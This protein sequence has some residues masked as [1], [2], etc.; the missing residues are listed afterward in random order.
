MQKLVQL[1]I[2]FTLFAWFVW[3]VLVVAVTSSSRLLFFFILLAVFLVCFLNF[4]IV[5]FLLRRTGLV[6]PR[7]VPE[8]EAPGLPRR[9]TV[10]NSIVDNIH[11]EKFDPNTE[12]QFEAA[13]CSI[14]LDDFE[15]GQNVRVLPCEHRFHRKCVDPWLLRVS[16]ACP[17]CKASV[18]TDTTQETAVDDAGQSNRRRGSRSR[19]RDNR[20]VV[21]QV[22]AVSADEGSAPPS[23]ASNRPVAQIN[24]RP[25]ATSLAVSA[26]A[27]QGSR[28]SLLSA[29]SPSIT[30]E[31]GE[32]HLA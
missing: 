12:T 19:R 22:Q 25:S 1:G 20:A 4:L 15:S 11:M 26:V 27:T 2:A 5:R 29:T 30:L 3:V 16:D 24:S 6:R 10:P 32:Q 18:N 8:G 9:R 17:L 23:I 28:T 31:R 14:C 13:T 7:E 21:I